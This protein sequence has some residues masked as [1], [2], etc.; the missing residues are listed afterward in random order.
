MSAMDT[1][2]KAAKYD[3]L[4]AELKAKLEC[5][6]C[7]AV[8]TEGQM[9]ACPRGH[10]VCGSCRVKMTAEG[11]E[12][13][14][15]CRE[16]MGNNKS[17]LAMVVIENMEHK[18][19]NT[20]CKEKTAYEDVTKHREELCKFRP[21]LCP[22]SSC[23]QLLPLSSFNVHEKMCPYLA[24]ATEGKHLFLLS[25]DAY[26]KGVCSTWKTRIFHTRDETFAL[27]LWMRNNNLYFETVM[28]AGRDEC[29]R[30]MTTISILNSKS[31]TPSIG[32]FN[33]RPIGP[34]NVEESTLAIHKTNLAKVFT[35][36][37]ENK[38]VFTIDF[39]VS[40]KRT[41]KMMLEPAQT[42]DV[43]AYNSEKFALL[44]ADILLL[45]NSLTVKELP[46][47]FA[48][49]L[50][51]KNKHTSAIE[52]PMQQMKTSQME[53]C[54]KYALAEVKILVTLTKPLEL[55]P[56]KSAPLHF[57]RLLPCLASWKLI[58]TP[59]LWIW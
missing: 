44:Q 14:P 3:K 13:C 21:I 52:K 4:I 48:S 1:M 15:V 58:T 39:K 30:F 28:L 11:H 29:T 23:N 17:L 33:P 46:D 16:P 57:F 24:Q 55:L 43:L 5:P 38:L 32:Q 18:C 19:T 36:E 2:A 6:V 53:L 27:R 35:T 54:L 51:Q 59:A 56:L 45:P 10:L 41:C 49:L 50:R 25:N 42:M 22:G 9:L 12:D 8:P 20:G 37:R 31:V 47:H 26:D 40:E 7:L 34:T